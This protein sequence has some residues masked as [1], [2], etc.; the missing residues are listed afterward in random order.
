[1]FDIHKNIQG[2]LKTRI[3]PEKHAGSLLSTQ[4]TNALIYTSRV[5]HALS[6]GMEHYDSAL[7]NIRSQHN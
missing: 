2:V 4:V 7:Q 6:D 3:K 1:M 5:S